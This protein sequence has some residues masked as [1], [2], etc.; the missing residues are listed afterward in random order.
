MNKLSISILLAGLLQI[1]DLLAA[2]TS[3]G[4]F[5]LTEEKLHL[6]LGAAVYQAPMGTRVQTKDFIQSDGSCAQIDELAG[7]RVALG[8]HTQV[9][10]ERN[11]DTTRISLLKGWLK[12][13]PMQT[14]RTDNLTVNTATLGLDINQSASVIHADGTDTEVFLEAGTQTLTERDR[15]GH[16]GR[17]I[18]LNQEE[19]RAARRR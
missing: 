14:V 18:T 11:G 4:V 17:K 1:P 5:T 8:P 16:E 7:M 10:L 3:L 15:G 2:P 19:I 12:I 6:I 13:Q 9:Y